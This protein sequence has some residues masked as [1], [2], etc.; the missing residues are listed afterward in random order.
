MLTTHWHFSDSNLVRLAALDVQATN[1]RIQ[2]NNVS[3]ALSSGAISGPLTLTAPGL[4]ASATANSFAATSGSVKVSLDVNA[5]E[6]AAKWLAGLPVNLGSL[7]TF[8]E[9]AATYTQ[10]VANY[11]QDVPIVVEN[12]WKIPMLR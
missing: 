10:E 11:T 8:L 6:P 1:A 2:G 5:A 12:G 7:V 3:Y 4:Q 9:K